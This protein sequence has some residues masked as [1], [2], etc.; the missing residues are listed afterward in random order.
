MKL[1]ADR[2]LAALAG[3]FVAVSVAAFYLPGV[4]KMWAAVLSIA[5]AL[6]VTVL[7]MLKRICRAGELARTHRARIAGIALSTAAAALVSYA[8]MDVWYASHKARSGEQAEVRGY[9]TDTVYES[10][11]S[12]SYR[13]TVTHINGKRQKLGVILEL[14]YA[15][16]LSLGDA[17]LADVEFAALDADGSFDEEAYYL[18]RGVA[19][20]AEIDDPE[21]LIVTGKHEGIDVAV[22]Q[23]RRKISAMLG[24]LLDG[25][26]DY[27]IPEA[28]FVGERGELDYEVARNFRYIGA[29]HMLAVSGMHLAI[30]IGGLDA[31]LRRWMLKE[32]KNIIL[33]FFTIAYMALTGFSSSVVR[34]GIMMIIYYLSHY[35]RREPDGVTSLF[36]AA[37]TIMLVSPAS[38]ADI[39]LLLSVTAMLGCLFADR[40]F[41]PDEM[42]EALKAFG[43]RGKICKRISRAFRLVYSSVAISVSAMLFTL[44]VMWLSFGRVS[45]LSPIAA[46]VLLLP[47]K[48]ILYLCPVMVL[49]FHLV[50]VSSCASA[51][52][53]MLCQLIARISSALS[54]IRAAS[55]SLSTA[56]PP[57]AV[58]CMII[59]V[60]LVM[61]LFSGRRGALCSISAAGV[62]F[63]FVAVMSG[64]RFMIY[65]ADGVNYINCSKNDSI[66][67]NDGHRVLIC[68]ISDGSWTSTSVTVAEAESEIVNAYMLTHLHLRHVRTFERLCRREYVDEVWLPSPEEDDEAVV[69][70]SICAAAEKYG[71]TVLEYERGDILS[72]GSIE[73]ETMP[74][75]MISRSTHPV[76]AVAFSAENGR[77]VYIGSSVHESGLYE[78]A[79]DMCQNADEVVF[80]I[81]GPVCRGGAE[82]YIGNSAHI[83]FATA[84]IAD[85]LLDYNPTRDF[86]V[87]GE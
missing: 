63:I 65:D 80:G 58:G 13:V 20:T 81:H 46:L 70:A 19:V 9:V 69:Y 24:V 15:A 62:V 59:T 21:A 82:Y 85:F 3:T 87:Y 33:I 25:I 77:T 8:Y 6:L 26:E 37:A 83:T 30:L 50:P 66:V 34:A 38:A 60:C 78:Y 16:E 32:P 61:A 86:S 72:F 2:P 40:I 42:R 7:S 55:V 10:S 75:T 41:I 5:T 35:A 68:D 29:S 57:V 4:Y 51:L 23:M 27:G 64:I 31:V 45:L 14:P 67:I 79:V 71:V 56:F 74:R 36:V 17:F 54:G 39:G 76:I 44:P 49:A 1:L 22:S 73:I 12:S 84:E 53:G 28:L 11:Y 43:K 48:W 52:C 18:P 47:V